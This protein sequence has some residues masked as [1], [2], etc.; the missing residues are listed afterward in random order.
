M[1]NENARA[2]PA[3]CRWKKRVGILGYGAIAEEIVATL[4]SEHA[5]HEVCAVL[6]KPGRLETARERAQHRFELVDTVD[7]LLE[8]APD[9]VVE[10]AGQ[11]ALAEYAPLAL[12]RGVDVIA[13]S[14]GALADADVA[15]TC[16]KAT[17]SGAALWIPSGAVAGIDGLIAS[18]SAGLERVTYTSTKPPHAWLGTPAERVLGD[19]ALRE[20]IAFF[21]GSAREAA[22]DY[23][24]NANVGAT[25]AF[26]GLGL[27]RTR[28]VLVSDPA[29]VAPLGL[30]EAEGAFGTFRFE[31]LAHASPRNP[32][33]SLLTAHSLIA[34]W[35]HRVCFQFK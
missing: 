16:L 8:Q 7:A 27:D 35:R 4:E 2:I 29:A 25:V 10:A 6:V 21:E 14:V 20:R 33:T 23:P 24:K 31:I 12:A 34:A 13:S 18:R 1:K 9:V 32:K 11:G 22:R 3:P 26:A 30:I 15:A 17:A 28:V 5:L 19:R